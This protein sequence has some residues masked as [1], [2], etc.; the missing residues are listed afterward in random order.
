MDKNN[1]Y[2][3]LH[4][5]AD[6]APSG[7]EFGE[8]NS[9][10]I[11]YLQNPESVHIQET[12]VPS[13][14]TIAVGFVTAQYALAPQNK[15]VVIYG[16][17]APRRRS[18][19][20]QKNNADNGIKYAKLKNGVEIIN[21][22]SEFAFGFIKD[23]IVE[24]KEI[25]SPNAGSQFRSRDFFPERVAKIINNDYSVLGD[26]LNI[27]HIPDIPNNLVSWVDGFG[28]IKTTMRQS[29]LTQMGL[30]SGDKVNVRLNGINMSGFVSIGGFA[31]DCG[32][33]AINIGSSG[34]NNPFIEFFLRVHNTNEKS[35]SAIFDY[36]LGGDK[37]SILK[38]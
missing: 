35:A 5:I 18:Q 8:I 33:L 36:P 16:N 20:A 9:K 28:N 17:A 7:M 14:D 38:I 29:D 13:L 22:D 32:V 2:T 31:V 21:V 25:K 19:K 15:R 11:S 27:N 26:D 23:Q 3:L 24:F 10:L 12:S 34:Y 37:F 4:I 30:K 1:N 6:Y